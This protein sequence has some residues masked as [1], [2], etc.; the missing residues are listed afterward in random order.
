[1]C[2]GWGKFGGFGSHLNFISAVLHLDVVGNPATALIYAILVSARIEKLAR[3]RGARAD[4][5]E[6]PSF[7]SSEVRAQTIR[8]NASGLES[9]AEKKEAEKKRRT[10]RNLTAPLLRQKIGDGDP[11]AALILGTTAVDIL[12][13][14]HARVLAVPLFLVDHGRKRGG[15]PPRRIC[16][17]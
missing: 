10:I 16:R 13:D 12:S 2:G 8:E 11:L 4:F 15:L 17:I 1:M 9:A 7:E 6:L 3:D 5:T 14:G